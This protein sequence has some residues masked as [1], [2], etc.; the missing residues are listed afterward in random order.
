MVSWV[1]DKN[2]KLKGT[3]KKNPILDTWVYNVMF[4]GGVVFQYAANMIAEN[5]YSQI[6]SN[7]HHTLPLKEINNN[8]KSAMS[9]P[10]YD[11]FVVS[12]TGRK[13]IRKTTKEWDF[14]CLWRDDS[15]M[16][17]PLKDIKE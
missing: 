4:P 3:Y 16:S 5:M 9:V 7:S 1:K 17:S 14:L 6:D 12:K 11:K 10:I 8:R 13:S 2:G 15:T